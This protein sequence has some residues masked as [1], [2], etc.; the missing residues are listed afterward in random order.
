MPLGRRRVESKED[1]RWGLKN[2]VVNMDQEEGEVVDE[3]PL[4]F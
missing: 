4:V 2:E 3:R 1:K